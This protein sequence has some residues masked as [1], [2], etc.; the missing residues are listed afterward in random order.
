LASRRPHPS[1][2]SVVIAAYNERENAEKLTRRLD[3][4]LRSL[5]ECESEI[6]F[7][8]E[9]EDGTRKIL[10]KLSAEIPKIR[11]LY[12]KEPGGLGRA[13]RRGFAAVSPGSDY[14]ITMDADLNHQPEEIP[15]LL[16]RAQDLDADI[17][18]GSRFI[19]GGRV[20]GTPAWKLFL[21]GTLNV[22][23]R[24]VFDLRVKDKTSG[25]RV[26]RAEALRR[27]SFEN[28]NFAFVPEI[29]LCANAL[30]MHIAEE[31]I[32]FIF[33]TEGK[34]KMHVVTTALSYISLL[35]MRFRGFANR[36]GS[37]TS[38]PR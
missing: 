25:Y 3:V 18:V 14:V 11:I 31:P 17:L 6:L 36:K 34:S 29:L 5:S 33:R 2:I 15:R 24:V 8:V 9:G 12:G 16:R 22:I 4:V 20:D 13:F 35:K 7:V 10:E 27:L 19:E 21:S 23:M 26:Y 28:D 30:G 1:K 38:P 32:H 37:P